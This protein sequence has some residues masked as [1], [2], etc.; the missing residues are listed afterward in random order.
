VDGLTAAVNVTFALSVD[1]LGLEASETD[2][3]QPEVVSEND[4]VGPDIEMAPRPDKCLETKLIVF[5]DAYAQM[6]VPEQ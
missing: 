1:G 5:P 6:P 4:V 3:F 2:V